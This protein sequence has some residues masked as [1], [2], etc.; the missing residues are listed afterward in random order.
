MIATIK[1]KIAYLSKLPMP[2]AVK[3]DA[4]HAQPRD[5]PYSVAR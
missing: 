4:I 1:N 5:S 2:A 3:R